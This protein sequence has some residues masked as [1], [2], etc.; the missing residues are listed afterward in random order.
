M[1]SDNVDWRERGNLVIDGVLIEYFANPVKQI[2]Y[3]FEKEFKQ[4]KRSTA[5]IITIGK[6]LFDKTGIAEE[7]KKEALKYMKKPFEKPNEVG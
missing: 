1:L 7:L 4:N 3:Y 2:K 5:R 6:V